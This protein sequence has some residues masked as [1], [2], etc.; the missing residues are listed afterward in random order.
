MYHENMIVKL[1]CVNSRIWWLF[2]SCE[3]KGFLVV[4]K[5]V[6]FLTKLWRLEFYAQINSDVHKL[7]LILFFNLP[8][9]LFLY[10]FSWVERQCKH[11]QFHKWTL[12]CLTFSSPTKILRTFLLLWS[13]LNLNQSHFLQQVQMAARLDLILISIIVIL[14]CSLFVLVDYPLMLSLW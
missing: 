14:L 4:W 7:A 11:Q 8:L 3:N 9:L 12:C 2:W 1:H 5:H 6:L 13:L 10:I